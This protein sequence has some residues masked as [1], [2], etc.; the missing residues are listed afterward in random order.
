MKSSHTEVSAAAPIRPPA[1]KQFRRLRAEELVSHGD[2]VQ[3]EKQDFEPW[4]GPGGFRAD[5]FL[6]PIYRKQPVRPAGVKK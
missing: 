6:K 3:N 4:D 2:F 1:V 5:A